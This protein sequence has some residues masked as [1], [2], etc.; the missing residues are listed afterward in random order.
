MDAVHGHASDLSC[1]HVSLKTHGASSG[2]PKFVNLWI[3]FPAVEITCI[4][5][6]C[7]NESSPSQ[8]SLTLSLSSVLHYC[9]GSELISR[10]SLVTEIDKTDTYKIRDSKTAQSQNFCRAPQFRSQPPP[11]THTFLKEPPSSRHSFKMCSG[12]H[13]LKKVNG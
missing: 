1:P 10:T 11:H 12:H 7:E 8:T 5:H 6:L 13:H 3:A 2:T 9:R 4:S